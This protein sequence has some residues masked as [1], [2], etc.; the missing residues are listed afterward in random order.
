MDV[1]ETFADINDFIGKILKRYEQLKLK[2]STLV[3][4]WFDQYF[5]SDGAT[6]F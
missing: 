4:L 6:V 1:I 5:R 2:L 3:E